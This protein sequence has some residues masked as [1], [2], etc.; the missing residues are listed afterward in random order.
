MFVHV[1][2]L[3]PTPVMNPAPRNPDQL[4][5][6]LRVKGDRVVPEPAQGSCIAAGLKE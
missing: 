2:I 5:D 3:N 6:V 1:L 4:W